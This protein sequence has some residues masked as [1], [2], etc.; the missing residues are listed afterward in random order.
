MDAIDQCATV[1]CAWG[2]HKSA[3]ARAAEVLAIIRICG[4][5]TML[6]HLG[7]NKDGSPKHPLYVGTRTRPQ[8]FSA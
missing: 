4:R 2:A 7:L 8:H 6:H 3:P 1:I 5:A